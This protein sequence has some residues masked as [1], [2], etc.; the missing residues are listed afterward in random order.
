MIPLEIRKVQTSRGWRWIAEGARI[1]RRNPPQ[2]LLLITILF[3]GSRVLLLI[4]L[5]GVLA[6]LVAPHFLA[7]LAH[8]AQALEEGKPLRFGYLIS[9]FLKGAAPLV[10]VGGISLIGQFL[11]L[12]VIMLVGGE[13]LRV[14]TAT[15]ASGVATP[16]TVEAVRAAAPQILVAVMIGFVV[17][18]PLMLAVWFAPLLV[19][20]DEIKPLHALFL[21]LLACARNT[22]PLLVYGM[23]LLAPVMVLTPL[24]MAARM[25][26]LGFWLLAPVMVPSIYASYRDLFVTTVAQH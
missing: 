12:M 11:T 6:V 10:T 21:S 17:S 19:F 14:I 7:G 5:A 23:I 1:F 4:P 2:W 25:P 15:M 16:A 26:D 20:F 8:G 9:G 13:A 22:M 3:V 18:L 24:S